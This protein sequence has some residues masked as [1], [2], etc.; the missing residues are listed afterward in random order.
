MRTE[1]DH[2]FSRFCDRVEA[3][4]SRLQRHCPKCGGALH[5]RF[6]I[7]DKIGLYVPLPHTVYAR[8]ECEACH[9]R[10]R[11]F[12]SLTDLFLEAGWLSGLYFLGEF[13]PLAMA[14]TI[15]W[16][17]V[18]IPLKGSLPRG[19]TDTVTAGVV[20]GI[21]WLLALVFGDLKRGDYLTRHPLVLFLLTL[22]FVFGSVW[23]VLF[24]DRYTNFRL[25]EV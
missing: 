2:W 19:E 16:L 22:L 13:R 20:T 21:V 1:P 11:S 9:A 17:V 14:G 15:T 7:L 8:H 18:A 5:R 12:R 6:S 24:L 4:L 10:F 3:E 25:K 23:V